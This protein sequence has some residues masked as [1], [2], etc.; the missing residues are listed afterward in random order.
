MFIQT[1]IT[2]TDGKY[3]LSIPKGTTPTAIVNCY[4]MSDITTKGTG[5]RFSFTLFDDPRAGQV[6]AECTST[7][8]EIIAAI[9]SVPASNIYTASVYPNNN[10]SKTPISVNIPLE[11]MS[12]LFS[13][14]AA[15]L[16]WCYYDEGYGGIV[17]KVL[18]ND[19][20]SDVFDNLQGV[21]GAP[22]NLV[23]TIEAG[24]DF[25]SLTWTNG[26]TNQQGVGIEVSEDG[27]TLMRH[28]ITMV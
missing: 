17:K 11:Q 1:T 9:D 22:S 16:T 5:S 25:S 4:K 3:G 19:D 28:F 26:A 14:S 2:W 23:A 21:N 7:V 12:I 15:P 6:W 13:Y 8:A 27:V 20:L 10:L 24:G 18:I